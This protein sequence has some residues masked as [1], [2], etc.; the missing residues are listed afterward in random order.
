[1]RILIDTIRVRVTRLRYRLD[2]GNFRR[3]ET[4]N[5]QERRTEVGAERR[6]EKLFDF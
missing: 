6:R 5:N 3:A 4:E 2:T 1:M